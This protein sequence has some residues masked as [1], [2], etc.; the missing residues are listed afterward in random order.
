M[1]C[2]EIE[3]GM[4]EIGFVSKRSKRLPFEEVAESGWWNVEKFKWAEEQ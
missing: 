4:H 2:V 1:E 3:G